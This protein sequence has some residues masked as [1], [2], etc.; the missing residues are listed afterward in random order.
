[1]AAFN[2]VARLVMVIALLTAVYIAYL[3]ILK[4]LA[5]RKLA[6][7]SPTVKAAV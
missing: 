4:R 6:Q 2:D 3:I 1:M 5:D 7:S